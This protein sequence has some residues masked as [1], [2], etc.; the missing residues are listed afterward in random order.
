LALANAD[1]ADDR[2]RTD[3]GSRLDSAAHAFSMC[4][5]QPDFSARAAIEKCRSYA[6]R[7]QAVA[8][9][10][11]DWL[12]VGI[13]DGDPAFIPA[14]ARNRC[15]QAST[16]AP[17]SLLD[18]VCFA[19]L[20]AVVGDVDLALRAATYTLETP[21]DPA[22]LASR[23]AALAAGLDLPLRIA[24][25]DAAAR[26]LA[27]QIR[28]R[29]ADKLESLPETV[30]ALMNVDTFEQR[31]VP[32]REAARNGDTKAHKAWLMALDASKLADLAAREAT[33]SE[34]ALPK[35]AALAEVI[36]VVRVNAIAYG[37]RNRGE[38]LNLAR[39]SFER[40]VALD[41]GHPRCGARL[42]AL[43]VAP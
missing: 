34:S 33:T 7:L 13:Q 31:L 35:D 22:E 18:E 14:E 24:G 36:G 9:R 2:E 8:L 39:A 25:N 32:L 12:R 21:W 4:L 42:A 19:R 3:A 41:P 5:D 15:E 30:K 20:A 29:Y 26:A 16:F 37:A 40:C 6:P 28:A 10:R 17:G 27:T 23:D 1:L 11:A 38:I 43:P